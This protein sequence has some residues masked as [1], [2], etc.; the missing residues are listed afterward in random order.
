MKNIFLMDNALQ[1][2]ITMFPIMLSLENG[3]IFKENLSRKM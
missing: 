3:I 1:I 2:N